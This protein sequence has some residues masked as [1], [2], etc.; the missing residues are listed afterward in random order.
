MVFLEGR[1]VGVGYCGRLDGGLGIDVIFY[2]VCV[3]F[4]GEL[5]GE[6]EGMFCRRDFFGVIVLFDVF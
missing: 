4:V 3:V 5:E 6:K 1:L 2:L